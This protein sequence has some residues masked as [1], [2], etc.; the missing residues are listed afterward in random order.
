M[1]D[2]AGASQASWRTLVDR[3]TV[4]GAHFRGE[5]GDAYVFRITATDRALNET[6]ITTEPVVVP[7]DDRSQRLLRFS[8]RDWKRVK[9]ASAW[10]GT[11][12]RADGGRRDRAAP[13]PRHEP[14][15]DRPQAPQGRPAARDDRR[16]AH[17]RSALR[18]RSPHRSVLWTS[19]KLAAGAPLA[20]PAH[21]RRRPGRARRRRADAVSR[22]ALVLGCLA[23]LL[24][25]SPA[26]A[27]APVVEQM[28]VFRDG[29]AVTRTVAAKAGARAG[30][31][32]ALR[33]RRGHR[34][35]RARSQP[36]SAGSACATTA[37][38]PRARVTRPGCS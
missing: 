1:S 14:V 24:A 3:T 28:V 16:Q 26:A 4:N 25:A 29:D 13:L 20:R 15:A 36:R 32:A 35:G 9:A 34:A 19:R 23:A 8:K 18:G 22:R 5:A 11:V 2:G 6:T 10:G 31:R 30:R 38:A 12:V 33:G 17:A 37:P 27:A 21:A 7:V